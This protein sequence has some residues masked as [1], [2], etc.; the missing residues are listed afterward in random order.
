MGMNEGAGGASVRPEIAH[1]FDAIRAV[2]HRSLTGL[3]GATLRE[4]VIQ[5][6]RAGDLLELTFAETVSAHAASDDALLADEGHSLSFLREEC[7]MTSGRAAE[8]ISVGDQALQ[9]GAAVAALESAEIG[10]AHLA[11]MALTREAI[12]PLGRWQPELEAR[13]LRKAKELTVTRFK[14]L[15]MHARHQADAEGFLMQQQDGVEDARL[16]MSGGYSGSVWLR[17]VLPTEAGAVVRTALEALARPR[18]ADDTRKREVRLAHA[19][20][21]LCEHGLDSR[22]APRRGGVRPHLQVTTTLETLLSLPGAP[23]GELEFSL[24]IS[25]KT[26]Q[27]IACDCTITRVLL[28]SDSVVVDVGRGKANRLAF[29]APGIAGSRPAL[30]V[31]GLRPS[32][33]LVHASPRGFLG[34]GRQQQSG[35]P[36]LAL[37]AASLA[38]PRGG[39]AA[40][41]LSGRADPDRAAGTHVLPRPRYSRR[42]LRRGEG[43]CNRSRLARTLGAGFA[44]TPKASLQ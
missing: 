8:A 3:G 19:L 29:G 23:A 26:V 39:V 25:A 43:K 9:L 40:G 30:P 31:A 27:R 34:A 42:G 16:E 10:F 44:D 17:A 22:L 2:R 33:L 13:L 1:L 14:R 28:G 6:R 7:Q 12:S 11:V 21:E 41:P 38:G 5:L 35:Q 15:C 32:G 20:V 24:P 37:L 36:G 4:E 18:G